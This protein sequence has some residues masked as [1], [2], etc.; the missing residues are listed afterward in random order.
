VNSGQDEGIEPLMPASK[1]GEAKLEAFL[2]ID[3]AIM[4]TMSSLPVFQSE[5]KLLS[6]PSPHRCSGKIYLFSDT[7]MLEKRR[8]TLTFDVPGKRFC[9]GRNGT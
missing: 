7:G 5:S 8:L 4:T 2:E 3:S 9:L 6:A 1:G